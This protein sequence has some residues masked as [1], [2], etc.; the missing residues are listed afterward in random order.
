LLFA[1][2]L[3]IEPEPSKILSENLI[4]RPVQGAQKLASERYNL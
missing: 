2:V 1:L 3:R 4:S